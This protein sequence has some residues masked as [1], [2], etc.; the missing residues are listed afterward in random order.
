MNT[1]VLGAY[2]VRF[3]R[4]YG[5][6]AVRRFQGWPRGVKSKRGWVCNTSC[7]SSFYFVF[8]CTENILGRRLLETGRISLG[9]GF[10][11]KGGRFGYQYRRPRRIAIQFPQNLARSESDRLF[12]VKLTPSAYAKRRIHQF[13]GRELVWFE[14][15]ITRLVGIA[16]CK[17]DW[18]GTVVY[19]TSEHAHRRLT[20]HWGGSDPHYV[21]KDTQYAFCYLSFGGNRQAARGL[22]SSFC[23]LFRRCAC[24]SLCIGQTVWKND[25]MV[26]YRAAH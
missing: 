23:C 3:V 5:L 12:R 11:P 14:D 26:C 25:G 19:D 1:S 7:S 20:K 15:A 21:L 13:A 24:C 17:T 16:E 18:M 2:I 8:E 9:L 10:K 4:I 6:W 22:C